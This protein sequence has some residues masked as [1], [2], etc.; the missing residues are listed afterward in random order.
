MQYLQRHA[1]TRASKHPQTKSNR[2][3]TPTGSSQPSERLVRREKVSLGS[4]RQLEN[5]TFGWPNT[6]SVIWMDLT[7]QRIIDQLLASSCLG[8][9]PAASKSSILAPYYG[10]KGYGIVV[11]SGRCRQCRIGRKNHQAER[12]GKPF[13]KK[14]I[15]KR[16]K[17]DIEPF[18]ERD[19]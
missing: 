13:R 11:A 16:E 9:C 10:F 7:L 6:R 8:F 3:Q 17:E 19:S 18:R 15:L 14:K 4:E 2:T 12:S 5:V 1:I